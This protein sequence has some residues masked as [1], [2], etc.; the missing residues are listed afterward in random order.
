[1]AWWLTQLLPRILPGAFGGT[2]QSLTGQGRHRRIDDYLAANPWASLGT[3]SV[4]LDL[5]CGFPPFTTVDVATRFRQW[6]VIG[7]D[8]S[9]ANQATSEATS[10][11]D[12]RPPD[13]PI[14][15]YEGGNLSFIQA[16]IGDCLPKADAVRCMNVLMYY[17][18][19]FRAQTES[20]LA[21]V[22]RP[23]GIFLCGVNTQRSFESRYSVYR[24]ENGHLVAREFA[25]SLDNVRPFSGTPW[26]AM[27]DGE[28]ETWMLAHLVGI[29][30]ADDSFRRDYDLRL[31]KLLNEHRM[32][33]RDPDGC[34]GTP[35]DPIAGQDWGT[36]Y[37]QVIVHLE[38]EGFA[39]RAVLVLKATG[40]NAWRNVAG[41]IA[42]DPSARS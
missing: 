16:G 29:L 36:T 26:F 8:Q 24:N 35:S 13:N 1:M 37:E 23:E 14:R 2:V 32:L 38:S 11:R 30:R 33:E 25:F 27:H 6:Q 19:A 21:G 20:W 4:L 17:D 22:L 34:L 39:E 28:R 15:A 10:E 12:V 42:I 18:S 3:G 5:G 31:D 41:H 7:V 40:L 9:F